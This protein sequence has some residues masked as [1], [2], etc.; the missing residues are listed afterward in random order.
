MRQLRATYYGLMTEVD[1]N[2]GRIITLLKETGQYE[3]TVI[4]FTSDHGA[5]L[6]DHYLLGQGPYFD[7][8]FHVPLIIRVPDGKRRQQ[9]GCVIDAFTESIDIFPT[10][11]DI[12][13]ADIPIQCD[14]RSLVP[15]LIGETPEKFRTEVHWEYDFRYSGYLPPGKGPGIDFDECS[16]NVIRDEHYKY[17]YFAAMPD[18]L[19][20]LKKD[21]EELHNLAKDPAYTAIVLKYAQKMLSWRMANDERTLTYMLVGPKGVVK[22][23][24]SHK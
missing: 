13:G 9:S 17:V 14:G 19:F 11:M 16:L 20:D 18:L 2:I 6:G 8:T 4:I 15:F 12:F 5:Q 10:I 22:R 1:E 24:R 7:Q 3:N 21:P 23:P